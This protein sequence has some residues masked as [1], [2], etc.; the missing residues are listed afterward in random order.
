MDYEEFNISATRTT[1]VKEIEELVW[2]RIHGN[3]L[4]LERNEQFEYDVEY[5]S[6]DIKKEKEVLGFESE[7]SLEESVDEVIDW[8][9]EDWLLKIIGLVLIIDGLLCIVWA[10]PDRVS[11]NI[12]GLSSMLILNIGHLFRI[13]RIIFGIFFIIAPKKIFLYR[14]YIGIYILLDALLSTLTSSN[15]KYIDWHHIDD[16]FRITRLLI[17]GYL[18]LKKKK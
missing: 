9:K 18:I 12:F 16:Y 13:V 11:F 7:I 15:F 2:E 6:H 10:S 5:R 4:K 3:E 17:G 1:Y 8:M 14:K